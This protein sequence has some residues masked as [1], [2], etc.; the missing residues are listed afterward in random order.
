MEKK[1]IIDDIIAIEWPMFSGVNN[2]GGK[3]SCQM[4][5]GTFRIMRTS[6]YLTWSQPLLE[7]WLADLVGAR[8]E[9][10]N[11]M[12]EKYARMMERTFPEEYANLA[13]HLP[14]LSPEMVKKVDEIVAIHLG[15]K[16]ELN[17]RFPNLSD[18]GRPLRSS[19]DQPYSIPS[20]ET[21]MRAELQTLSPKSVD[22][23]YAD[24]LKRLKENR[25]EA[26]ENLLNQVRQYGFDDLESADRHFAK[27]AV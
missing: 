14:K 16:E 11:L 10:R 22:I 5:P 6:Q 7:S 2:A 18:R 9:G 24:T 13:D 17:S 23:Y 15:W 8:D 19:Q 4:D 1:R 3:A 26:E 20:L 12:S 21:Y 25:S 27:S